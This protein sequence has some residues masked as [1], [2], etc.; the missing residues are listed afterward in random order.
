M[1]HELWLC[2]NILEIVQQNA[3]AKN[4]TRVK[5]VVL[6]IGE[7]IAVE[8]NSLVFSF[9]V[10]TE[11]T[12]AEK[13]TLQIIEVPGEAQCGSCQKTVPLRH[14]YDQCQ[15]CGSHILKVTQGEELRV[16]SMEVE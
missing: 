12:I 15:R 10:I 9:N 7:L 1:M 8:K 4:C 3:R 14:Y 13:A 2:R 11:G 16:K 5:K 6:E